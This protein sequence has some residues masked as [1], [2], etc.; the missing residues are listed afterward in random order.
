MMSN[1]SQNYPPSVI[2]LEQIPW[3]GHQFVQEL[4]YGKSL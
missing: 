2:L 4:R 3:T 1:Y